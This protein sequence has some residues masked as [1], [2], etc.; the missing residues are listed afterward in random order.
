MP[1][2]YVA[3]PLVS[4]EEIDRGP[5]RIICLAP[6]ITE[7]V[8]ALGMRNRLVGRS[9]FCTYPPGLDS[10]PLVGSLMDTNFAKIKSLQPDLVLTTTNS[11]PVIDKLWALDLPYKAVP[12][13]SIDNVY[14]AITLIG[15]VCDRP[16]TAG[17][18]NAAIQVDI[19]LLLES[20]AALNIP[21]R[22]VLVVLGPLPVPPKAVFV[23]GPNSFLDGLVK[24][25]GHTNV[26]AE[27]LKDSY[28]EI[29]LENLCVLDPEVILEF[30]QEASAQ[31]MADLYKSWSEVGLLQAIQH[32]RVRSIG[33]L[34]WL[35]AGPR[36]ALEFHRFITVLS[37]FR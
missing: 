37:E 27:V 2:D 22:R 11:G 12:H 5:Q 20:V 15:K 19:K 31:Y 36:I 7:I 1:R 13:D 26:A 29:P 10:V 14:E 34:E 21:P 16:Q 3:D 24:M 4:T 30:Q 35:S 23:A 6:N 33:G 25:A 18:L 32:Q 9:Q 17:L 28:G 8:C